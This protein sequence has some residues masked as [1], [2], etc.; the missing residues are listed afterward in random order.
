[1]LSSIY[2]DT[3]T[4]HKGDT[5][6]S[7]FAP[8][9]ISGRG[10]FLYHIHTPLYASGTLK[11]LFRLTTVVS[12]EAVENARAWE[13]WSSIYSGFGNISTI[14]PRKANP[15]CIGSFVRWTHLVIRAMA[16][17]QLVIY[18][19]GFMYRWIE[20]VRSAGTFLPEQVGRPR[21]VLI[22]QVSVWR[23]K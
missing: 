13:N 14:L 15:C 17:D 22:C 9:P 21:S 7:L 6:T 19:S 2:Q 8:C 20:M 11:T 10:Q 23:S 18:Q 4:G 1:M 12:T 3:Q 16:I 5:N